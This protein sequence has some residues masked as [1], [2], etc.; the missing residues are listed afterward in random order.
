LNR[1]IGT[2][3]L[4]SHQLKTLD[5]QID[6]PFG[7]DAIGYLMYNNDGYMSVAIM[8]ANRPLFKSEDIK[9]GTPDEKISIA[10]THVS[11]CGQYEVQD[12]KV[13][14]H[15]KVSSFPNWTDTSQER[16]FK[17]EGNRLILSVSDPV[18]IAGK[19]Q[20]GL[21]TWERVYHL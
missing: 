14:H 6:Y 17:F 2:W 16:I 13:I 21:V 20:V 8:T 10:D 18:L 4:V 3:K 19:Q 9:A 7:R 15:V 1:F 5:N 12:N 11:Y